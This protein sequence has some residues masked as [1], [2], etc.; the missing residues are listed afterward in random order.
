MKKIAKLSITLSVVTLTSALALSVAFKVTEPKILFQKEL[1]KKQALQEV[2]PLG[3]D[4]FI[5]YDQEKEIWRAY[6]DEAKKKLVAMVVIV[7]KWGYSSDIE[8]MVGIT[9]GGNITGIKI[10]SHSE[11]PGLGALIADEDSGFEKQFAGKKCKNLSLDKVD[12]IT[13]ATVSSRAVVESIRD[14]K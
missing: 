11:T 12:A 8:T 9:P 5:E 2:L 7:K 10:I 13:G 14:Y 4:Y 1:A 3:K 6:D